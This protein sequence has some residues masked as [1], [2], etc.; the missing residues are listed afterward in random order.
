MSNVE[1]SCFTC[2]K[3][4]EQKDLMDNKATKNSDNSCHMCSKNPK[5]ISLDPLWAQFHGFSLLFENT[6]LHFSE[7]ETLYKVLESFSESLDSHKIGLAVNDSQSFHV[8]AWDGINDSN[9]M[10]VKEKFRE[11]MRL[12]ISNFPATINSLNEFSN[13]LINSYLCQ[14]NWKMLFKFDRIK[15]LGNTS[16]VAT[17]SPQLS[18][19]NTFSLFIDERIK[20]NTLFKNKYGHDPYNKFTPHITL[21]N[22]LTKN[23]G[24]SAK[25][26]LK[27]WNYL[28]SSNLENKSIL[29]EKISLFGFTDM[30]NF[31]RCNLSID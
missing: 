20:L 11:D 12:Y 24:E 28:I 10:H 14:S 26:Y 19:V 25:Q 16:L 29:F 5:L 13:T 15:I 7:R 1:L 6:A 27:E 3:R 30:A 31:H 8:T 23:H 9:I 4:E 18:C 2:C 21:G 22:F 17:L